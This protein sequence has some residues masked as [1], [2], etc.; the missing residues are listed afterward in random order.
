MILYPSKTPN[1]GEFTVSGSFDVSAGGAV[2]NVTGTG[3]TVSPVNL[4]RAGA[5]TAGIWMVTFTNSFV[6][7]I[8]LVPSVTAGGATDSIAIAETPVAATRDFE[9]RL[10]NVSTG[11]L[12]NKAGR[13]HFVAKLSN[14]M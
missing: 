9:M 5:A 8:S 14:A 3:F 10:W 12:K 13:M 11:A 4:D 1:R 6:R 7:V 2:T